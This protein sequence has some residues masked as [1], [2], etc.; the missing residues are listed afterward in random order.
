LFVR[1]VPLITVYQR[2]FDRLVLLFFVT[3]VPLC[4]VRFVPLFSLGLFFVGFIPFFSL[5]LYHFFVRFVSPTFFVRFVPP[6]VVR[7][8][9][10]VF[11]RF[12]PILR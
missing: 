2:F 3:F 6:L 7:L 5:G 12:V 8:V 11:V 4:F 1:F 9:L 10:L